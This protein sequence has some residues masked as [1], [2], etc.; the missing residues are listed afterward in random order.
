MPNATGDKTN[1]WARFGPDAAR[2]GIVL[3]GHTDVVP[4]DGQP[5]STNPWDLAERDG[6]WFARGTT[7]MKGFVALAL[8]HAEAISKLPLKAPVHFAFSYDEEVGCAGVE[9]MISGDRAARR[10]SFGG[11]GRRADAVGRGV[12]AQGHPRLRSEDHRQGGAFFR[13]AHGRV[14]D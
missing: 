1:L 6:G 11:V 4:I 12:G 14:G 9:P 2:A 10:R 7:D 13:S 5:W 8:A 3:S